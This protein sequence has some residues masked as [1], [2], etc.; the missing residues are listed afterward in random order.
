MSHCYLSPCLSPQTLPCKCFSKGR[1]G[2]NFDSA[3]SHSFQSHF[4]SAVV[5]M[6]KKEKDNL[7]SLHWPLGPGK[8]QK[9]KVL[10]A[11]STLQS[12][13]LSPSGSSVHGISQARIL[14]WVAIPFSRGSSWSRN[15]DQVFCIPGGFFT[16]EPSG[17]LGKARLQLNFSQNVLR[18]F[19]LLRN[20]RFLTAVLF[21]LQ[22]ANESPKDFFKMQTDWYVWGRVQDF[23]FPR[24][25]RWWQWQRNRVLSTEV[26]MSAYTFLYRI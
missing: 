7:Q 20:W 24:V 3:R 2:W 9:V 8:G 18:M 21:E 19:F 23:L 5:G 10:G 15:Q 26:F 12:H 13:G 14:E 25:L 22:C 6:G 11:R 16:P 17:K 4:F 1:I